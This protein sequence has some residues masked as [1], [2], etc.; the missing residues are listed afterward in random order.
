MVM[1]V[2]YSKLPLKNR[3]LPELVFVN[4]SLGGWGRGDCW[5]DGDE[6]RKY[7]FNVKAIPFTSWS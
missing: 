6:S 7:S 2:V 1:W 4:F 5:K 3:L